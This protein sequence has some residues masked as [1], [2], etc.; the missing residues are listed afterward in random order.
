MDGRALFG[1]IKVL[2]CN[3]IIMPVAQLG[4]SSRQFEFGCA[5]FNILAHTNL[6]G[7]ILDCTK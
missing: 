6:L 7:N 1:D 3:L 4:S 2:K 5:F